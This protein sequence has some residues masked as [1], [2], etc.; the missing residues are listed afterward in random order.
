MKQRTYLPCLEGTGR[1][2]FNMTNDYLFRYILQKHKKVLVG[3][4][5]SLLHL[6]PEEI[7]SITI[8]N[9]IN[10]AEEITGKEFVMDVKVLLN[11]HTILNL[12]M[13]VT[14][15]HNWP[16]RSL[17]Y[18]CRSF[19]Q[20]YRGQEYEEALP[21]HHIAFLNYTLFPE[22]PEFYAKYELLN[23]RNFY[24]YS[25]KF[26]LSVVSLN[27]IKL[28]NE[29]DRASG[30][31]HWAGL[32]K[33]ETWEEMK[34]LLKENEYLGEAAKAILEANADWLVRE[35]C[36]A[37]ELAERREKTLERD[38][39]LLK[40]EVSGL[41]GENTSLKGE[42]TSLKG[43]VS[44]LQDENSSL[45]EQIEELQARLAERKHNSDSAA[46]EFKE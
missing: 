32:F 39:R 10:L 42:N 11:D 33:A 6:K 30:L 15:Q 28:A 5:C 40:G 22:Y 12:E 41:K 1:I 9:P 20:L 24:R 43:E 21:V 34:M 27:Q 17:S 14:N 25:S 29:E 3:L 4:V 26:T 44:G 35:R 31:D 13:Q 46:G 37:R 45:K 7:K 18:L 19:D 2:R 36:I 16:E 23:I 38:I 8:M